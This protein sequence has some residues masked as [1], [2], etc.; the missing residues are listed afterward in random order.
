MLEGVFVFGYTMKEKPE[1]NLNREFKLIYGYKKNKLFS[2]VG[3]KFDIHDPN[4]DI[5]IFI[6][7]YAK[8]RGYSEKIFINIEDFRIYKMR[9]IENEANIDV[10]NI[11]SGLFSA[12][13]EENYTLKKTKHF[14]DYF[15]NHRAFIDKFN[16]LFKNMEIGWNV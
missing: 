5:Q 4:I 7:C 6:V 8:K 9:V 15:I 11:L 16:K 14:Y 3:E 13:N 12:I 10:L 1:F 2:I